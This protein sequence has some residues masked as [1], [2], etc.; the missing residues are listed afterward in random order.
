MESGELG[1]DVHGVGPYAVVGVGFGE[2]DG[3]VLLDDEGGG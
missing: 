1:K 3:V 2:R